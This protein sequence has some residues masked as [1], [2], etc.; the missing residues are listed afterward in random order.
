[1]RKVYLLV[2]NRSI[3][4]RDELVNIINS[5]KEIITWRYDM[6][7]CFYLLSEYDA[8]TIA[9]K[10]H[11][12]LPNDRFIISEIGYNYWGWLTNESWYLIQNK[13]LK[14]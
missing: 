9:E 7:S 2:H 13:E 14:Q 12:K 4:K 10:L 1:M 6:R 5:I 3:E 8:K 11:E